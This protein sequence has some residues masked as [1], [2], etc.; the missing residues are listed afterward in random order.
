MPAHCINQTKNLDFRYSSTPQWN[1]ACAYEL[2]CI[3]L[4]DWNVLVLLSA[5]GYVFQ[6]KWRKLFCRLFAS[7]YS[8]GPPAHYWNAIYDAGPLWALKMSH[9]APAAHY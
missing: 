5:L 2:V 4:N 6:C 1:I 3:T 9:I 8:A 7:R